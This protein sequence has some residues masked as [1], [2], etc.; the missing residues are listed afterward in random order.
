MVDSAGDNVLAEFSSVVDAVECAVEIQRDLRA[1]NA[2]LS[3]SRQ[4]RFRIGINLGDVILEGERLYGD[5]VNIAARVES[6]AEAGG[7]CL[8]GTAYDQVEGKLRLQSEFL[9]EHVVKN[10]ARPVRVYRLRLEPG[11][12]PVVS[13]VRPARAR[14]RVLS[15]VATVAAVIAVGGA[16]SLGW[17][18]LRA[19]APLPRLAVPDRPSVA[20]LPFTNLTTDLA[21]DYF[22][23]GVTEDIIHRPFKGLWPVRHR[24]ELG[25]HL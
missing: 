7:I 19:P 4:M 3:A 13:T 5:G 12:A 16:G 6:L 11:A 21:Q 18:W 9:G 24:A 22:S 20:V 15:V 1:R 23:D 2:E 10:I 8:S 25:L 17:R 14:R